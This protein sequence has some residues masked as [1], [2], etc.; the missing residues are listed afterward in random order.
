MK[1][2]H[3][4]PTQEQEG[5]PISCE[6]LTPISCEHHRVSTCEHH[7]GGAH[8]GEHLVSIRDFLVDT[9]EKELVEVVWLFSGCS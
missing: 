1:A 7:L 6:H 3:L 8:Q 5:T 4:F 2:Y 9:A